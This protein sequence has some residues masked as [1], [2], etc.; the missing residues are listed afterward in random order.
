MMVQV[1][2][3]RLRANS[4]AFVELRSHAHVA[5]GVKTSFAA[6][7]GAVVPVLGS[8]YAKWPVQQLYAQY[9]HASHRGAGTTGAS[10]PSG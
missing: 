3:N 5:D 1:L 7:H 4:S 10:A 9:A 6:L 8:P 2:D